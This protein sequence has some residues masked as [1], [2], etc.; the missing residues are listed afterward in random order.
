MHTNFR[1][2]GKRPLRGTA[3]VAALSVVVASQQWAR[4][5]EFG[6][7]FHALVPLHRTVPWIESYQ[8]QKRL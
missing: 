7:D 6:K 2:I 5:E 3:S 8:M 4:W 1:K